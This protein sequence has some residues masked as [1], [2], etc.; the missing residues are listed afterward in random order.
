V[1][2]FGDN[3]NTDIISPPAYMEL[4]IQEAAK[5][6]MYPIDP[7]FPKRFIPGGILVAE[8]NFGSGS[9][10]ETAPLC[11]RELGVRV[12]L[13][14]D[15][16][17]IFYRTAIN[18]GILALECAETQRIGD[19]D[20]ITINVLEGVVR[21]KTKNEEYTATKMP[22]HIIKLVKIGGMIPYLENL[23]IK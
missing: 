16:A 19:G 10:R 17:R 8:K 7:E 14:H 23:I 18:L 5:Y 1:Y 21:N 22:E 11:L 15:F 2:K 6:T 4:S 12:I 13:A 20:E 3:I 9:S